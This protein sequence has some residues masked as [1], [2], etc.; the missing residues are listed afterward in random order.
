MND[1]LRISGVAA[2]LPLANLDTDQIMPKQFLRGIDK[3]GLDA[4][5][6]YDMRFDER[7][8]KRDDFVLNRPEYAQTRVL[9]AGSNFGCGSSREHAVWGLQQFGIQAVI[10]SSFAEI[11]H[12]NAMNNRLLLVVLTE[13]EV[14]AIMADAGRPETSRVDIDIQAMTVRSHSCKASF[15]LAPR[16]RHMFLEG[17]DMIGATLE[18]KPAIDAFAA[19]HGDMY[20]WLKNVAGRSYDRL[21]RA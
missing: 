3:S 17:L 2:P 9:V 10:A 14:Q 11:F 6:F 4:G 5:V 21:Q 7:G 16:H 19:R 13:P 8:R 1:S 20:P 15:T 12:A 18:H